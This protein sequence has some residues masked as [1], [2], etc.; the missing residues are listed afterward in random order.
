MAM[1]GLKIYRILTFILLPFAAFLVLNIAGSLLVSLGNPLMLLSNFILACLPVYIFTSNYF[2]SFGV[3]KQKPCKPTLKD[4]IKV[5]AYVSIVFSV[6]MIMGSVAILL[7]LSNKALQQ[8]L[9][10]KVTAQQM[11]GLPSKMPVT[12]VLQLLKLS[13]YIMLPFSIILL[14]HLVFTFKIIKFYSTLFNKE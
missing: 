1:K 5:N 12:E 2:L 6:L 10:G 9:M 3:I 8:E 4:W 13:V 7:A 14:V 11:P